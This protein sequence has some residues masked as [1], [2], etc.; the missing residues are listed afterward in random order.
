MS[1]FACI[2]AFLIFSLLFYF[3]LAEAKAVAE[4]EVEAPARGGVHG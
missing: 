2:F 4:A 1:C 3:D